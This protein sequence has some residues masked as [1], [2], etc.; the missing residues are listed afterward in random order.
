MRTFDL[1]LYKTVEWRREREGERERRKL[2]ISSKDRKTKFRNSCCV[3]TFFT[4]PLDPSL[5]LSSTYSP[6]PMMSFDLQSSCEGV[7]LQRFRGEKKQEKRDSSPGHS[8]F[9]PEVCIA[10]GIRKTSL[11]TL[12]PIVSSA[13]KR[14]IVGSL[15]AIGIM[16]ERSH[17][18]R[19]GG[20]KTSSLSPSVVWKLCERVPPS[21]TGFTEK[22]AC[23][24]TT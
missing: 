22:N 2:C 19:T 13:R 7:P 8:T 23:N 3:Y 4:A 9:S 20:S 18:C 15:L 17:R 5:P 14:R 24:E 10:R 21:M 6:S 16:R 1:E 12:S 11:L